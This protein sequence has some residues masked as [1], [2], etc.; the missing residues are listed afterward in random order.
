[1]SHEIRTPMNGVLGMIEILQRSPLAAAQRQAVDIIRDSSETLIAIIDDI[2]DLSKIEA[3]RLPLEAVPVSMREIVEGVADLLAIRAREKRLMVIT[4]LDPA[5]PDH[6]LGDPVRLRQILFNLIG[7]A[8]KFTEYGCVTVTVG[9]GE[10]LGGDEVVRFEVADTGIGISAEQQERLF[11]P[12]TQADPSTTR[13]FG[14]S[15]LGLSICHRLVGLMGGM[16]GADG[17]VGSGSSFWFE[18]PLQIQKRNETSAIET[19]LVGVDVVVVEAVPCARRAAAAMVT[20]AGA[21]V[22]EAAGPEDAITALTQ[23][24]SGETPQPVVVVIGHEPGDGDGCKLAEEVIGTRGLAGVGLVLI[25]LSDYSELDQILS[26]LGVSA[27]LYRPVRRHA[28]VRAVALAAGRAAPAVKAVAEAPGLTTFSPPEIEQARAA[29]ALILI[30]EDN[31]TNQ[32][33]IRRQLDQLGFAAELARDGEEAWAAIQ[34]RSFGLLLSDCFM[35]R[36]DGYELAQRIRTR[37]REQGIPHLPVVAL[38]ASALAGEAERCFAAGMD[39]YLAKPAGMNTLLAILSRWL[40]Q[41]LAL[42]KP[43]MLADSPEAV[44][45]PEIEEASAGPALAQIPVQGAACG[46]DRNILNLDHVLE[47]FGDRATAREMLDYFLETTVPQLA[48]VGICLNAGEI[49]NARANAHAVAGAAR[50]AGAPELAQLC[51]QVELDL[52]QGRLDAARQALPT[53]SAAMARVEREIHQAL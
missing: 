46:P 42:R 50:T 7:N 17:R 16:I 53:L 41:A 32:V 44:S 49:D 12:F 38:T 18:L 23:L 21:R 5:I 4:D 31:L 45:Q 14:G 19:D 10:R 37:E 52:V 29:G 26:R 28:L 33:V 47:V 13:R 39:D 3:G 43:L 25:A 30:A 48:L 20:A 11:Q 27:V 15:G 35:P 34:D 2:L 51:S 6:R 22:T 40:P 8:I 36:M 24:R 1:M 9:A